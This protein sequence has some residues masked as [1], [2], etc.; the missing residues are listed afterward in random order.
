MTGTY[1]MLPPL[2]RRV[3]RA[4]LDAMLTSGTLPGT[5]ELATS[6][7]LSPAEVAD[8]LDALAQADYL[9][10]TG[11]GRITCLYPFSTEPTPHI[12]VVGEARRYAM[13]SIDALGTAA[14]LDRPVA[15]EATC[16]EC[17]TDIRIKVE[18]GRIVTA[19]PAETVVV[20]RRSGAEPAC[21]VCCPFTRF[22]CGPAHGEALARRSPATA[23]VPLA[24]A[25][26]H[27]E[28]IFGGFLGETL[29]ARR[30]R[31]E[32]TTSTLRT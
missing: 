10:R 24:E 8:H 20:A 30:P 16:G 6:V 21:E 19:D 4:L 22:A 15:I 28:S 1:A 3:H 7:G 26:R 27:A 23:V 17:G 12:V 14:M 5:V 29:P 31:S 13:C 9:G 25:L 11:A 2:D 32:L 18:P